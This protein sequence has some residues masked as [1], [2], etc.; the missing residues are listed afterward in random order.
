MTDT[1]DGSLT[2]LAEVVAEQLRTIRAFQQE[3]NRMREHQGVLEARIR[4]LEE[5]P[6]NPVRTDAVD[7]SAVDGPD[8]AVLLAGLARFVAD[9]VERQQLRGVVLPCWWRHPAAVEELGALWQA[10]SFAYDPARDATHPGWWRDVL[11]RGVPRLRRIFVLCHGGHA[12]DGAEPW[13]SDVDR[14][15][16]AAHLESLE[17]A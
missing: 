17:E 16:F 14:A 6:K 12:E 2:D 1:T 9:L 4:R 7:W 11:D 8:R 3:F 15:E 5:P 13:L 10:R